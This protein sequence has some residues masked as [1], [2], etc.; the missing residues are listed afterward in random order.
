MLRTS[1]CPQ[2]CHPHIQKHTHTLTQISEEAETANAALSERL[3]E[4]QIMIEDEVHQMDVFVETKIQQ[5]RASHM[6]RMSRCLEHRKVLCGSSVTAFFVPEHVTDVK[7][8]V[9]IQSITDSVSLQVSTDWE[10]RHAK[11]TENT[12]SLT[13]KTETDLATLTALM[14]E[15]DAQVRWCCLAVC[16]LANC[17]VELAVVRL[18]QKRQT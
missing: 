1:L 8:S 15:A 10:S 5:V 11:L 2:T 16:A 9:L 4:T 3:D 17:S 13:V 7:A 12:S 6:K 18:K 14:T